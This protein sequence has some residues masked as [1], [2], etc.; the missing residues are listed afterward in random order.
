MNSLELSQ[1]M[2]MSHLQVRRVICKLRSICEDFNPPSR[3][4]IGRGGS[5]VF[6][7]SR[8][9]SF[10]I[11][12][13]LKSDTALQTQRRIAFIMSNNKRFTIGNG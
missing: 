3:K 9:D 5:V 2:G 13:R 7:L 12:M 8:T 1:K 11:I 4:T 6:D 10:L